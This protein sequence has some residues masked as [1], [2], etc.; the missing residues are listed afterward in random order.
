MVSERCRSERGYKGC[1]EERWCG[2]KDV[3]DGVK[4]YAVGYGGVKDV[5]E[6]GGIRDEGCWEVKWRGRHKGY[7]GCDEV[8]K[9]WG[10]K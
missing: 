1:D 7:E 5:G 9:E 3:K 6:K 8:D 2:G 10:M 4:G